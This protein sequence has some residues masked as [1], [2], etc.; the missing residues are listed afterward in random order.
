MDIINQIVIHKAYG[1]GKIIDI[2]NRNYLTIQFQ[3][4][5]KKF[6]YP[7]SF[8]GYLLAKDPKFD[9][10]IQNELALLEEKKKVDEE[11][12]QK[13]AE[14]LRVIER[15]QNTHMQKPKK[16]KGYPRANIAFKCNY[17]DGGQ[18][19][20]HVGFN[21]VCSDDAIHYNIKIAKRTWCCSEKCAC[22]LYLNGEIIRKELDELCSGDGYVCYESQMLRDWKALAG[23]VQTGEN[24]NQPMKLNQVQA[25]SLCIL[26]TRDPNSVETDRYIFAVFLVDENYEGDNREEGYVTTNSKFKINLTPTEA[27]S[28]L[29]WDF[30]ANENHPD[31]AAWNTGLHRYFNDE[32]AVQ[33]LRD[34]AKLKQGT[35]DEQLAVEFLNHFVKIN[36]VDLEG[37]AAKNGALQR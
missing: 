37:V 16:V 19:D 20:T 7:T 22:G 33:I 5:E 18:S 23:I 4:G 9:A 34:I 32:Q 6:L 13:T 11:I 31:V 35:S 27:H 17:C 8:Q 15:P 25:N 21:G 1:E 2:D 36:Q 14:I 30:H 24:K 12:I 26:T 29:F 28:M 10:I 3:Q